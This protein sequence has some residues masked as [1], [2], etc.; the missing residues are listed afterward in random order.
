MKSLILQ[1]AHSLRKHPFISLAFVLCIALLAAQLFRAHK[2]SVPLVAGISPD[3]PRLL[4][5]PGDWKKI[6]A[7]LEGDEVG[8]Q[9]KAFLVA[10]ADSML[11]AGFIAPYEK[12]ARDMLSS[13]RQFLRRVTIL[14]VAYRLTDNTAYLERV[15]K[16]LAAAA[17][18]DTWHPEHFLDTAE[19]TMGMALAYD[20]NYHELSADERAN[21][22]RAL[23]EKAFAFSKEVYE[24]GGDLNHADTSRKPGGN[25]WFWAVSRGNWNSVCNSSLLAAAIAIAEDEPALVANVVAV[26]PE[27]L[28]KPL[29]SYGPSGAYPEGPGYWIY[30]TGYQLLGHAVLESATGSDRG[31]FASEPSFANTVMFEVQM[32]GP[33][34][35][36]FNYAD[37]KLGWYA[38]VSPAFAPLGKR[39]QHPAALAFYRERL[40]RELTP[41]PDYKK[42]DQLVAMNALWFP[43]EDECR[44]DLSNVPLA[45]HYP[46][47]AD[48]AVFRSA[49]NDPDALYLG[50][51]AGAADGPHGHLD[52]GSFVLDADGVRWSSELG[53]DNYQLPD[54]FN[55]KGPRKT[56]LS[57]NNL[58]H[59]TLSID[60]AIMD[61]KAKAD[62]VDFRGEG[63]KMSAGIN[64]DSCYPEQAR[65]WNRRFTF[66]RKGE[67]LVQDDL[68]GLK[69][70]ANVEWRMITEARADISPDGKSAVLTLRGKKLA[71]RILS[72]DDARFVVQ[73]AVPQN[74]KENPNKGFSIFTAQA[75]PAAD[76]SLR[77]AV[78][79]HPLGE[80][81]PVDPPEPKLNE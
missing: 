20:W 68:Q 58:G 67:V 12:G 64:L 49:W 21:V 39:F 16:E 30:G 76:G 13:S 59:S 61:I 43:T 69:P 74:P 52:L 2:A 31:L 15:K 78:W 46:G 22:R 55:M 38:G 29:A 48:V 25:P 28:K 34:G 11:S 8:R 77:L 9:L 5:K 62:I 3:H 33:G 60:G 47:I 66:E 54:Y 79:L 71:A 57:C 19:L 40:R 53:A 75:K 17:A 70:E 51:K 36:M 35:L 14:S 63:D 72:P 80:H 32:F 24:N 26:A 41:G 44:G 1:L 56:Y 37:A 45:A 27:Y 42:G 50:I 23:L 4:V 6:R 73:T 18:L 7:R 10:Q 81:W 65:S